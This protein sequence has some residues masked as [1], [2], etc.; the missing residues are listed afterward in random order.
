M[1]IHFVGIGGAGLSPLALLTKQAGH[2]V[3]GSDLVTSDYLEYLKDQGITDVLVGDHADILKKIHSKLP[4]DWL[5]YSS[6]LTVNT[7]KEPPVLSLAKKLGIK[8]TKRDDFIRYF[9]KEHDQKLI[10]ISGTH[11]KTTTTAMAIWLLKKLNYPFS[12][13]L[14]AKTSFSQMA[15]FNKKGTYFIYE[16]DEFDRNFLAFNPEISLISGLGYDHH[17]IYPTIDDYLHAFREFLVQSKES[18]I[19]QSDASKLKT[20]PSTA[21]ILNESNPAVETIKLKGIYNRRDA[22]LVASAVHGLLKVDIDE[23]INHLNAFPGLSRRMEEL[24]P[25]LYSDYAHTVE[26]IKG[27]V[28]TAVDMVK[29]SK[30]KIIVIYEPL[31]NRRQTYIKNDYK[32]CFRGVDKIYWVDSYLA[33]EEKGVKILTPS[34]L[35]KHLSNS[36]IAEAAKMDQNLLNKIKEHLSKGDLVVAM[37]GGGGGSLDDWLRDSFAALS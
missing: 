36:K 22:F 26:K 2:K 3:S 35:I 8:A 27:A 37:S 14:P 4:V 21:T 33:R 23:L 17:E 29:G 1:H 18:F 9:L 12:Y 13:M 16:A 25:G 32:D 6:A 15:E 30:K 34:E 31:T 28:S 5:V 19:W 10:A 11:G 20:T 24:A 7:A